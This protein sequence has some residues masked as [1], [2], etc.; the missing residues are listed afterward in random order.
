MDSKL[1]ASMLFQ[2]L[3]YRIYKQKSNKLYFKR[4]MQH[5]Y[6]VVFIYDCSKVQLIEKYFLYLQALSLTFSLLM[7][8]LHTLKAFLNTYNYLR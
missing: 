1:K 3:L 5:K 4:K 7:I 2:S 8:D 6:L